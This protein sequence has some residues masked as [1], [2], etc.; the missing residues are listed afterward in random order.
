MDKF[1]QAAFGLP[2][3]FKFKDD[4]AGDPKSTTLKGANSERLGSPLILRPVAV[5]NGNEEA[6]GLAVILVSAALPPGGL[7]LEGAQE[8]Y[9]VQSTL[10][11]TEAA[12]IEPLTNSSPAQPD[13]LR[14]F[15]RTL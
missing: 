6:I 1:P 14:A 5:G 9:P 8:N 15:L 3:I 7:I 13:V 2:I 11:A 10:T 12:T 4:N